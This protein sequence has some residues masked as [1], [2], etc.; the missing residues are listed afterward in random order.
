LLNSLLQVISASVGSIHI[1]VVAR[2]PGS[3]LGKVYSSGGNNYGQ[4]GHGDNT[5]HHGSKAARHKL[6]LIE[7][8]KDEDVGEVACGENHSMVLSHDFRRLYT[9]GRTDKGALG[10]G[11]F[12]AEVER[13]MTPALVRFPEPVIIRAIKAGEN[14]SWVISDENEV[15]SWG[16]NECSQT[17]HKTVPDI[18]VYLPTKLNV[19]EGIRR[20]SHEA[21]K[22]LHVLGVGAGPQHTLLLVKRLGSSNKV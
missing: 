22:T 19:L 15:W 7:Y 17:G 16:F 21:A 5:V 4:L 13:V 3:S 12:S 11:I 1:L 6:K 20:H 2:D 10:L 18:D 8:L 9:F 14:T